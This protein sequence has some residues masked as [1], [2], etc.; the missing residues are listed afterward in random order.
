LD[1]IE[2]ERVISVDILTQLPDTLKQLACQSPEGPKKREFG[3]QY[4]LADGVEGGGTG[5][6]AVAVPENV[7]SD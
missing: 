3:G 5:P 2:A 1:L 6:V 4:W 7:S